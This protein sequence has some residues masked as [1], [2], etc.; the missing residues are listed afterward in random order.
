MQIRRFYTPELTPQDE[1]ILLPPAE[2]NHALRVLRLGEGDRL[3]LLN[4]R[5]LVAEAEIM[6]L[7]DARRPKDA[8]CRIL[9][10]TEHP[11]PCPDLTLYVAPPRGKA[12]DLVLKAACELGF[13]AIQ[14][15]LC[16]YGVARPDE[17]SDGWQETLV[18]ALKQSANPWMPILRQPIS[19]Q[20]ALNAANGLPG[21]F[22]ASPA[23]EATPHQPLTPQRAQATQILWVGPEGGF[24]QAEEDA[25]LQAGTIPVT[26]GRCVLRVETAV[27]A[28]AGCLYGLSN[29]AE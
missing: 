11:A 19:F 1:T 25:L 5:G 13:T 10:R 26:L 15:I 18:S 28:L 7:G 12:F 8:P 2:A 29:L 6:N 21:V 3:Q 17:A 24:A 16:A 20:A 23:A 14:P 9:S 4:G 22:G 27:P